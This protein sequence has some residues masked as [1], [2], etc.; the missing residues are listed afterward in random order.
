[1]ALPIGF[2]SRRAP[3]KC[4]PEGGHIASE[5]LNDLQAIANHAIEFVRNAGEITRAKAYVNLAD[6]LSIAFSR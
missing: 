2:V 3:S 4:L 5:N 6:L 1:M